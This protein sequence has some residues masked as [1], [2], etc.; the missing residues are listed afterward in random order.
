M[1]AGGWGGVVSGFLVTCE[2][3]GYGETR[4][5]DY[6]GKTGDPGDLDCG[7]DGVVLVS[8]I[9]RYTVRELRVEDRGYE[10]IDGAHG[11]CGGETLEAVRVAV[12][13]QKAPRGGGR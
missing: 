8:P 9:R 4:T 10:E 1:G 3:C 11:S 2:A 12:Y 5:A 13:E 6:D 7:C